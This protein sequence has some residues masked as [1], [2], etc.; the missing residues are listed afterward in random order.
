[1]EDIFSVYVRIDGTGRIIDVNSDAFIDPIGWT[2][3]DE[4]YGDQYH[5]AQR[6]YF[7]LP[8][9][10]DAGV[11]RYKLTDGVPV[12]RTEEEMAADV[13]PAPE[14]SGEYATWDD[15]AAAYKEGVQEA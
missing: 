6:N 3:I 1:M 4:G 9:M 11:Y 12:E 8:I 10:T 5:H 14:A 2:K 13:P 15:L 7:P